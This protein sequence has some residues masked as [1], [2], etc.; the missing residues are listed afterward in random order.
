MEKLR[1]ASLIEENEKLGETDGF[2]VVG[3]DDL[4]PAG[5][6]QGS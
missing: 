1:E 5:G 6:R 3:T 2:E 4:K